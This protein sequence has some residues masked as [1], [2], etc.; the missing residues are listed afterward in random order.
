[1]RCLQRIEAPNLASCVFLPIGAALV[2]SAELCGQ[3]I[4]ERSLGNKQRANGLD[5]V[6]LRIIEENEKGWFRKPRNQP[7]TNV[8][9]DV[10]TRYRKNSSES[11][12]NSGTSMAHDRPM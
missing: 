6:M 3:Y 9:L 10:G 11:M 7:L 2:V 12:M 8:R 4:I 1:M 5:R